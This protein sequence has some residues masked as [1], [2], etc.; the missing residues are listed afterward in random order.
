ME[1]T[2]LQCNVAGGSRNK[3]C[4]SESDL[5]KGQD[6]KWAVSVTCTDGCETLWV[7]WIVCGNAVKLRLYVDQA[8]ICKWRGPACCLMQW[9]AWVLS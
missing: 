3:L 1:R 2:T 4:D 9:T 6:Q 8:F 5:L 7:G